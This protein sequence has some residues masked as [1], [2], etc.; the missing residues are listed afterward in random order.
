MRRN[1]KW[2]RQII[3]TIIA[4]DEFGVGLYRSDIRSQFSS[5]VSRSGQ[6][7]HGPVENVVDYHIHLLATA[8]YVKVSPSSENRKYDKVEMT[9]SGHTYAA[10]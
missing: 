6:S 1:E 2:A 4:K 9:W 8:G 5:Y 3:E 10:Q 7:I